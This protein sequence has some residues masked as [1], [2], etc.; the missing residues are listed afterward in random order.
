GTLFVKS[1][2]YGGKLLLMNDDCI[3]SILCFVTMFKIGRRIIGKGLESGA[4]TMRLKG[5]LP[6][7]SASF[8][9]NFQQVHRGPSTTRNQFWS[10]QHIPLL[11]QVGRMF[12]T[13]PQ[14]ADIDVETLQ[15]EVDWRRSDTMTE[16]DNQCGCRMN[17]KNDF[18]YI[19]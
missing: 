1:L 12:S 10:K 11:L 17:L 9:K 3:C 14:F 13:V 7:R 6:D 19:L 5:Q 15:A 2:P 4:P 18:F 16:I 8:L